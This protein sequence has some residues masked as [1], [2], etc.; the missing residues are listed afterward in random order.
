MAYNDSINTNLKNVFSKKID[1]IN[2]INIPIIENS[3][4]DKEIKRNETR[5]NQQFIS[6]KLN[7][8]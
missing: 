1:K 7:F 5:Q 3:F 6:K 4:V 8:S 2:N